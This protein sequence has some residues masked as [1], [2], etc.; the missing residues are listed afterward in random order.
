MVIVK[1]QKLVEMLSNQGEDGIFL[2]YQNNGAG[3][4]RMVDGLADQAFGGSLDDGG[5]NNGY[6]C[7]CA[8]PEKGS[9]GVIIDTQVPGD[10]F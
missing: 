10:W 3:H 5:G 8:C 4:S 2:L 7:P 9:A 1:A 6:P